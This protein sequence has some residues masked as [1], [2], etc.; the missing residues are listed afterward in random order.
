MNVTLK[1]FYRLFCISIFTCYLI[2]CLAFAGGIGIT[3]NSFEEDKPEKNK[4]PSLIYKSLFDNPWE[5]VE[6]V[7]LGLHFLIV[8]RKKRVRYIFNYYF[9][10]KIFYIYA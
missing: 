8:F 4:N 1:L 6:T 10:R 7:C 5:I 3:I 9:N 2:I